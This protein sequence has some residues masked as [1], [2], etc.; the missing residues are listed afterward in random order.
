MDLDNQNSAAN[1]NTDTATP[2]FGGP[3]DTDKP[4][5]DMDAINE[6]IAAT[7]GK[8]PNLQTT[9]D[10]NSI[11]LDDVPQSQDELDKRMKEDPEMSLAGGSGEIDPGPN[12]AVDLTQNASSNDPLMGDA[13]AGDKAD[14]PAATFVDGDII[15]EDEKPAE[16][17][18]AA[19]SYDNINT[20]PLANADTST[21]SSS[22]AQ[23][24]GD[25]A[26]PTEAEAAPADT[27]AP[28]GEP[29]HIANTIT[30]PGQKS[31]LPLF[32]GIGVAVVVVIIVVLILI[33]ASK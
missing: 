19:P 32:I 28:A 26:Q 4:S 21:S 25:P 17:T 22:V 13:P 24:L 10:V 9:F 23:S 29:A 31:R 2:D 11:S 7:G 14:T 18:E 1:T 3:V 30:V 5:F 12:T 6:A 20:D 27:P 16:K 33:T 8:D 15:D